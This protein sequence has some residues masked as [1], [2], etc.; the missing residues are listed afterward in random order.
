MVKRPIK[1]MLVSYRAASIKIAS[2]ALA[3]HTAKTQ[4]AV[5]AKQRRSRNS[6]TLLP[7]VEIS[8]E[9]WCCDE[10]S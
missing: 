7:A 3:C 10:L 6:T 2:G 1:N 8:L 9:K 5:L 4:H